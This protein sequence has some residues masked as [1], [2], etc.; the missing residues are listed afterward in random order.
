MTKNFVLPRYLRL[1]AL[2]A[3]IDRFLVLSVL[4]SLFMLAARIVCTHSLTSAWLS[5]NLFLAW[6][7]YGISKWLYHNTAVLKRKWVTGVAGLVWLLFVPNSFYIITDLFHLQEYRNAPLWFDVLLIF[8]FAWNGILLGVLSI[9]DMEKV[10]QAFFVPR[11]E[12]IFLYPVMW[13]NALGVYIGRYLRYNTWDVVGSPV[14]LTR[15]MFTLL[16]HPILHKDEW[17]MVFCFS[18]FMTLMY[19]TIKKISRMIW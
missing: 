16:V 15:D 10:V 13:L 19:V 7:P 2:K 6:I 12:W 18:M 4:F 17:A 14:S 9:R 8:S 1:F 3:E 5:W 11:N